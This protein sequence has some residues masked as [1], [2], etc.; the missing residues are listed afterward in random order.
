MGKAAQAH[1]RG[2]RAYLEGT[3]REVETGDVHTSIDEFNELIDVVDGR[4]ECADDL[5][6]TSSGISGFVN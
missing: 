1:Q 4:S 3:V 6:L 2:G 5:S